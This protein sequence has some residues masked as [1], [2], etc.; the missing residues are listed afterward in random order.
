MTTQSIPF[1]AQATP[2]WLLIGMALIALAL[3]LGIDACAARSAA[4]PGAIAPLIDAIPPC[5]QGACDLPPA[6]FRLY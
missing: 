6:P 3:G 5:L 2:I 1:P 4:T